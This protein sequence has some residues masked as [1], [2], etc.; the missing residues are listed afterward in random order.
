MLAYVDETGIALTRIQDNAGA[1]LLA[2]WKNVV[3]I[4]WRGTADGPSTRECI[5][6]V[7]GVLREY[8]TFSV[9]HV[10]ESSAGVPR[11]DGR[12]GL[13][14]AERGRRQQRACIG[15]LLPEASIVSTLLGAFARGI[16]TLAKVDIN[17][18]VEQN[19]DKLVAQVV[20]L[21]VRDTGIRITSQ[22]LSDAVRQARQRAIQPNRSLLDSRGAGGSV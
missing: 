12:D 16:R 8:A 20:Y 15:A 19:L 22:E 4:V 1:C 14:A 6:F 3:I 2:Q 5:S 11:R 13:L 7:D 18:I 17:L 9:I 10:I 21:H